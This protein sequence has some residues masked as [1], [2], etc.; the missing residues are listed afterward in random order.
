MLNNYRNLPES[1]YNTQCYIIDRQTGDVNGDQ[2]IDTVYLIG[3]KRDNFFYENLRIVIEDG[4]TMH[5]HTI[6]L[7]DKYNKAYMPWLFLGNFTDNRV[8]Q[9]MVNLP[10]GGSGALTYYYVLSFDNNEPK[11]L[12]AP[13]SFVGFSKNMGMEADY[14]DGYKALIQSTKLD[15]S[16]ILDLSERKSSYEGTIYGRDN[17]LIKPQKGFFIDFPNLSV[18]R[19]DGREPYKLQAQNAIAGLSHADRLGYTITYWKYNADS[20]SWI[21]CPVIFF[22]LL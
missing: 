6:P 12:L 20:R 19:F 15:Q 9:I 10:V 18:V 14:L 22:V 11:V 16:Y 7:D 21:L 17:K 8:D 2:V 1:I 3:D 5:Q 4:R 13:E